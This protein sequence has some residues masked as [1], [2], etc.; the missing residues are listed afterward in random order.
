[1][2]QLLIVQDKWPKDNDDGFRLKLMKAG[3]G[4]NIQIKANPQAVTLSSAA[5]Y[6]RN[7]GFQLASHTD[8]ENVISNDKDGIVLG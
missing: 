2:P 6:L 7:A 4:S 3:F 1:M 5:I 8:E